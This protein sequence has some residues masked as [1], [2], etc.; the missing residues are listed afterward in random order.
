MLLPV[1]SRLL[2]VI[3]GESKLYTDFQ[4]HGVSTPNPSIVQRSTAI[5]HREYSEKNAVTKVNNPGYGFFIK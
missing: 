4:L 2:A 1:N 5:V 3:L